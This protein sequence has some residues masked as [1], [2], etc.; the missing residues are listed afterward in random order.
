MKM[1]VRSKTHF[2]MEV[3]PSRGFM[4]SARP[5]L[6]QRTMCRWPSKSRTLLGGRT[7]I[8]DEEH[9]LLFTSRPQFETKYFT[10][11]I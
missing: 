8:C 11:T 1:R 2:N 9:V 6:S 4:A 10:R 7:Q 3:G 5:H